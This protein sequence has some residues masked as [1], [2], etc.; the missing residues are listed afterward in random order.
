MTEYDSRPDTYKHMDVVRG[1]L[2]DIAYLLMMRGHD[3][4]H[5]KLEEPELTVFNEYTPLLQKSTYGS[6]E[7]KEFLV[8]MGKG[9]EHHYAVNDHHP[10]YFENGVHDMDLIQMLEMLC[11]WRA[12]TLRHADGNLAKSIEQNAERFG[13]GK[14]LHDLLLRTAANLGWL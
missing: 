2:L 6:D 4:D 11:D 3:H 7:Y 14:E 13:Y 1:Y 8:G 9:L 12:A 5:S 10:E